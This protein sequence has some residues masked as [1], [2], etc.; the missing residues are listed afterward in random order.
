MELR[1][2]AEEQNL[3]DKPPSA[4]ET[5]HFD[6]RVNGSSTQRE[7]RTFRWAKPGKHVA[8]AQTMRMKQLTRDMRSE[9]FEAAGGEEAAVRRVVQLEPIPTVEWWD[10]GLL[11]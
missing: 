2:R 5:Q 6:P 11:E 4:E 1:A 8:R 9:D 3:I 7:R 10:E